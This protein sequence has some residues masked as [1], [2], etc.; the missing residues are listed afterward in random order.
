MTEPTALLLIAHGS[1][2]A[3]ANADVEYFAREL[4]RRGPFS[5]VQWSYLELARPTIDEGAEQCL[6]AGAKGVVL[7]P[8][9]LSPGRHVR[10]DL[11]AARR[12]LQAL[13]PEVRF[14][15]AEALGRHPLL[16]DALL[17]RAA[18]AIAGSTG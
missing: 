8:F 12:R 7:L 17:D 10:E 16:V 14:V 5:Q 18:A 6:S 3:E 4:A 11:E 15:L 1:R 13:H 2:R 9:F